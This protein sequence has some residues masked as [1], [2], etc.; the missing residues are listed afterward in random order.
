MQVLHECQAAAIGRDSRVLTDLGLALMERDA[1]TAKGHIG[2]KNP[3]GQDAYRLTDLLT[4][5]GEM[6]ET[7]RDIDNNQCTDHQVSETHRTP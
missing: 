2:G 1:L 6:E 4:R 7:A 5:P 3:P